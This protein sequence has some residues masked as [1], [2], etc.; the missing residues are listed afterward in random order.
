MFKEDIALVETMA[1]EI[2]KE[3]IAKAIKE[4]TPKPV[5]AGLKV[6]AKVEPKI[7]PKAEPKVAAHAEAPKKAK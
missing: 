2:V 3:E 7:E 4:L 6:E 5:M 1:R